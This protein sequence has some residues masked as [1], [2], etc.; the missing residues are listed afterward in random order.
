[1]CLSLR[2]IFPH[3]ARCHVSDDLKRIHE[4]WM[5]IKSYTIE[6]LRGAFIFITRFSM[7]FLSFEALLQKDL[8]S[9]YVPKEAGSLR[10][11]TIE[12]PPTF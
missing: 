7:T 1:M 2:V 4:N 8:P 9:V 3:K 11:Y 5:N 6:C 10:F 12:Q